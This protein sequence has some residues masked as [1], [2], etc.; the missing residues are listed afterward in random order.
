MSDRARDRISQDTTRQAGEFL[1][2]LPTQNE[3]EADSQ[4]LDM[5]TRVNSD[6]MMRLLL[7]Y[8]LMAD[9]FGSETARDIKDRIERLLISKKGGGREDAV[10]VLKQNFPKKVEIEKGSDHEFE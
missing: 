7:Y 5:R 10:N 2:R 1:F 3:S 9:S 6:K 4:G 8:G